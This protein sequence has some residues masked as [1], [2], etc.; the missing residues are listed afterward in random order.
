MGIKWKATAKE[1]EIIRKIADRAVRLA[2]ENGG[3]VRQVLDIQMDIEATH[4][5]GNPLRLADLLA[6]DDFNFAQ[7]ILGI[8]RHLNRKTGKL[9]DCFL[10]RF[11]QREKQ[12]EPPADLPFHL[13]REEWLALESFANSHGRT[14][15]AQLRDMWM[16]GADS[17]RP[18]ARTWRNKIGPSGLD[19][20]RFPKVKG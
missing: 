16:S 17:S 19:K 5:N 3:Q 15:R 7:D 14:W 11:T 8:G 9:G 20:I 12:P 6:A 10:P 4:C 18:M 13:E 1:R 2:K